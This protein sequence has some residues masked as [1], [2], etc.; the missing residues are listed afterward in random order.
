QFAKPTPVHVTVRVRRHVWNLRSRR[1][2][3][4]IAGCLEEAV[5]RFGLRVI[6][7]SVLGNHIHLIV[8]ANS[9]EALAHGMQGLSIRIAKSLNSLMNRKGGVFDD[10]Y[11][12]RVL[13]T[14]VLRNHEHHFGTSGRDPFS[15]DGLPGE[16]RQVRLAISMSWLLTI[17]WRRASQADLHRLRDSAF[18]RSS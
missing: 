5:G 16:Q 11:D 2:Y 17:G 4:R 8:E 15:S 1:C 18:A 7:Y 13:T 14:Y 9:A 12:G 3:R 6:E 10:H